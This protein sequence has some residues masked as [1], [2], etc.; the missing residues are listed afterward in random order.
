MPRLPTKTSGAN[1]VTGNR[2]EAAVSALAAKKYIRPE[3][4]PQEIHERRRLL[5]TQADE[6]QRRRAR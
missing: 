4:T 5:L 3:P 6:L 1:G 2:I